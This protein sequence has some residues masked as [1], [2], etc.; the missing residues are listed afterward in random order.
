MTLLL[1]LPGDQSDLVKLFI[2]AKIPERHRESTQLELKKFNKEA[3]Y[4][5]GGARQGPVRERNYSSN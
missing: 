5:G 1:E 4:K 3:T 2:S